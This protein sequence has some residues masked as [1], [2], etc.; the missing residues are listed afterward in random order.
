MTKWDR[1]DMHSRLCIMTD[2]LIMTGRRSL[3]SLK[4]P[5]RKPAAVF[6][7]LGKFDIETE[8]MRLRMHRTVQDLSPQEREL[9]IKREGSKVSFNIR[10]NIEE[11]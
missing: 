10:H 8:T 4:G 3:A 7:E 1:W 6:S 11:L 5:K 2:N 9:Y